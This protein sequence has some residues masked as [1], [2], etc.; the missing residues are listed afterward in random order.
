MGVRQLLSKGQCLVHPR[1]RPVR[2]P[3]EPQDQGRIGEAARPG[4]QS[5]QHGMGVVRLGVVEGNAPFHVLLG[6]GH[7]AKPKQA[8][9]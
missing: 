1:E 5:I 9:P 7:L 8:H 2:M 3:K 4:V 6:L